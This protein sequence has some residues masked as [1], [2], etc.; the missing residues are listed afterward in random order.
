MQEIR[1]DVVTLGSVSD[2]TVIYNALGA[3]SNGAGTVML[4]GA[5]GQIE[6][7][8]AVVRF[9]VAATIP[10]G[11]RV[12]DAELQLTNTLGAPSP[13]DCSLH[14][15][16]ASWG[17][18]GSFGA[19]G[20]GSGAPAEP[21][22]TTWLHRFYPDVFWTIPGGDFVSGASATTHV[23]MDG[24]WKWASAQ[25]V[26]DVQFWLDY[27]GSDFGWLIKGD[28]VNLR[29]NKRF[30]THEEPNEEMRPR[31]VV[32]FDACP[33]DLNGDGVVDDADFV[34]FVF[35]YNVLDCTDPA[36]GA[37]CPADLN[38]DGF[39]DDADFVVFVAAYNELLC[40]G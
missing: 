6:A 28:E 4:S 25:V 2:N 27:P 5:N 37:G 23:S 22:D 18:A 29:T 31:L 26:K 16:L 34:V 7:R 33:A 21:G 35:A 13:E 11:S 24:V 30:S 17:E 12:L 38:S 40:A 39:V 10:A 36:M 20:Q 32:T 8:R 14:R 1:A 15:L 3:V 9:A 19:M